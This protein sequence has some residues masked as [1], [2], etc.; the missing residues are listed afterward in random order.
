[1]RE[2]RRICR[3]AQDV[4]AWGLEP[5]IAVWPNETA[6][7]RADAIEQLEPMADAAQ[8]AI[9]EP[10]GYN[11]LAPQPIL[12]R[13]W[14]MSDTELR[15]LWPGIDPDELREYAPWAVSPEEVIRIAFPGQGLPA[16]AER[17]TAYVLRAIDAERAARPRPPDPG[18]FEP[19]G[20]G[21]GAFRLRSRRTAPVILGQDGLPLP[22]PPRPLI[23]NR[24]TVDRQLS[25]VRV[26]VSELVTTEHIESLIAPTGEQVDRHVR[27]ELERVLEIDVRKEVPGIQHQIDI[28]R[29]VNVDLIESGIVGPRETTR[30]RPLLEDVSRVIENAHAEGL[31]VEVLAKELQ[32][33][34]GV[35]DRRAELLARDQTLKL[36]SQINRG[37]QQ[38]VG[39]THYRW[40]TSHDER[41][42][43][44]HQALSGTIQSWDAPP[45]VGLGRCEH[46]GGDYQCRCIAI[47]IV[48][49]DSAVRADSLGPPST[50]S[51]W[52]LPQAFEDRLR[53]EARAGR[54]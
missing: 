22:L 14:Q 17:V 35:S 51:L 38:A 32:D 53:L 23:V 54:Y 26:A 3:V 9:E 11:P 6:D 34:F 52:G 45:M 44:A 47:P 37:R 4:I 36:N 27:R 13:V 18:T 42:R 39:I 12:R 41:V 2:L 40:S 16:N 30:L 24:E 48:R 10:P 19:R 43:R 49:H 5:L 50:A 28:W 8:A 7:S 46:P 20:K 21:P 31:R 25:W 29:R 33:R 1:M 15:R